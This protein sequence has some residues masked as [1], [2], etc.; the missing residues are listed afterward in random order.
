VLERAGELKLPAETK[1]LL[2]RLSPAT[3]DRLLRT[4]RYRRP[5]CRA[6]P[7][8]KLWQAI[9]IRSEASGDGAR[10][11][12]LE[13][14]LVAHCGESTAGELLHTLNAVDLATG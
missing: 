4:H 13:M 14:D 11:G 5:R 8:T 6:K 3:I 10:P 12:F 2:V 7:R 9:P 1:R